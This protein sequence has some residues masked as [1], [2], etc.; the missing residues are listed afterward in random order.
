MARNFLLPKRPPA[1]TALSDLGT[2]KE[3][4]ISHTLLSHLHYILLSKSLIPDLFGR[5][6]SAATPLDPTIKSP[7]QHCPLHHYHI[8][9]A[10]LQFDRDGNYING[11][12]KISY[13]GRP[14]RRRGRWLLRWSSMSS[15]LEHQ[16]FSNRLH[17][18]NLALTQ[19]PLPSLQTAFSHNCARTWAT[20]CTTM[21]PYTRTK[22]SSPPPTPTTVA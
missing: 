1:N 12:A 4:E 19:H 9:L 17:S 11:P 15:S 7:V 3:R 10:P 22:I 8:S 6:S 18:A 16:T 20:N 14:A 2:H 13:E 21:T 5:S